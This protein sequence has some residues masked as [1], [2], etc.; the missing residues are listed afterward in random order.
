[1]LVNEGIFYFTLMQHKNP[2][3]LKSVANVF[4]VQIKT[5][6]VHYA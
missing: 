3:H 6:A 4:I 5:T 2:G 1:M